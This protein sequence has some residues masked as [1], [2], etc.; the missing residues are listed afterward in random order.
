MSDYFQF[1]KSTMHLFGNFHIIYIH[2]DK[3][4]KIVNAD[5]NEIFFNIMVS[6]DSDLQ[7]R[8]KVNE[9]KKIFSLLNKNENTVDKD[10]NEI[11]RQLEVNNLQLFEI[12]IR[13]LNLLKSLKLHENK[14]NQF[15]DI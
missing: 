10:F 13:Q 14:L 4:I 11:F 1:G 5:T 6:F 8:E 7:F 2:Q 12:K 9:L 3:Q 15:L